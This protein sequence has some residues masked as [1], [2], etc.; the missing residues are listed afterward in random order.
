M[1]YGK[2]KKTCLKPPTKYVS[3]QCLQSLHIFEAFR[4]HPLKGEKFHSR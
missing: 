3:D 2:C 4:K 1:Y